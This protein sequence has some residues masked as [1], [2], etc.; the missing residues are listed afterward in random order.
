MRWRRYYKGQASKNVARVYLCCEHNLRYPS[1]WNCIMYC[2]IPGLGILKHLSWW[3]PCFYNSSLGLIP[4]QVSLLF[5]TIIWALWSYQFWSSYFF[6][7]HL[8][9]NDQWMDQR[10]HFSKFLSSSVKP[11][12][13][14]THTLSCDRKFIMVNMQLG[15]PAYLEVCVWGKGCGGSSNKIARRPKCLRVL[16]APPIRPS[17]C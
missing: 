14:H 9:F 1:S 3:D 13:S 17:K 8:I 6:L 16:K 2:Q 12:P 11:I 5:L 10:R 15:K 7:S 4:L